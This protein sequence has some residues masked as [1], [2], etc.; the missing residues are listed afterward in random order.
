[1]K[2]AASC[3]NLCPSLMRIMMINQGS[4]YG[5]LFNL[6]SARSRFKAMRSGVSSGSET[7]SRF[8]LRFPD[9]FRSA[10]SCAALTEES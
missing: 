5:Q 1:M 7:T 8:L 9:G 2:T 6:I 10:R 4:T 3:G